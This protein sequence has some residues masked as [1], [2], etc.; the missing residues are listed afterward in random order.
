MY[1]YLFK[2]ILQSIP[3]LLGITAISF[4]IMYL[5]PGG[6]TDLMMDPKVKPEDR[7][8]M[9][10]ALGLNQPPWVLYGEWLIHVLQGDFGISFARKLPVTD[11]LLDRLPQT[12]LLMGC[13][14]L[15]TALLSIPLGIL[16]AKKKNTWVDYTSAFFAFLGLATPNFWLGILLILCFSVVWNVLPAGGIHGFLDVGGGFQAYGKHLI[17]P[18]ITLG[19]ADMAAFLRYTRASMIEVFDQQYMMTARSKGLP[20]R[21]VI[22]KHGLRNGMIPVITLFGLSLPSFF[23][24][25]VIVEKIFSYPGIGLLFLDAVFQRDYPVIMAITTISAVLVVFGNLLADILYVAVDP[26]IEY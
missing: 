25:A 18:G 11:L 10:E 6:P 9:R 8:R 26:R 19:M 20:E 12:L 21:I 7:E 23:G 2:R 3:L 24:G 5:S 13:A 1:A 4:F 17:L 16:A 22:Y 14:F 15:F